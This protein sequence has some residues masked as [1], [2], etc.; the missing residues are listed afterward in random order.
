MKP[1]DVFG[2]IVRTV[3]LLVTFGAAWKILIVLTD[4]MGGS[5]AALM[6]LGID[7]P[8]LLVGLWLLRGAHTLIN[9]AYPEKQ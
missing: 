6:R 8:V 2:V 5:W 4:L 3:G 9:F 7:V 1:A